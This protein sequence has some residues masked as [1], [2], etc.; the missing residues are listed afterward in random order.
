MGATSALKLRQVVENLEQI[1][2]LELFCA[3]QGVDF[4]KKRAG[5]DLKLGR[6]TREIFAAIRKSVPF[7][8]KDTYLKD[9]IDA[10]TAIVREHA[11][12]NPG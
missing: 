6:G 7:I 5:R 10:I 8:E 1:I 3:A 4:R 12:S 2:A 11:L 9:H